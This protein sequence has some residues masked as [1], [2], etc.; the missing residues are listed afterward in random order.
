M[1]TIR[2]E[3]AFGVSILFNNIGTYMSD[4]DAFTAIG[5]AG[6]CIIEVKLA[7]TFRRNGQ[8]KAFEKLVRSSGK[9]KPTVLVVAEHAETMGAPVDLATCKVH[10]LYV[11]TPEHG[12]DRWS[13]ADYDL[14][15]FTVND[16]LAAFHFLL[17]QPF[18]DRLGS[19]VPFYL[20]DSD[21]PF[22]ALDNL[23]CLNP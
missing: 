6:Y 13:A 3:V 19:D 12:H 14:A 16:F 5:N 8:P 10:S 4:I 2:D 7:G 1:R 23:R 21:S 22:V 20:E 17:G 11:V 15:S 9:D 18:E